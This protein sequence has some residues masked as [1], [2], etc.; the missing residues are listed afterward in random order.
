MLLYNKKIL[1]SFEKIIIAYSGGVDSHS[2]LHLLATDD[3]LA[4][5]V[6]AVHVNHGLS[7]NA[8][9]WEAY[10]QKICDA[11]SIP[12]KIVRVM[13]N[14]KSGESI[15]AAARN[16]RYAALANFVTK[17]EVL[18]T[19]QHHDDQ[20]ETMLLQLLR[21]AGVKGL[22]AMPIL[23]PFAAGWHVRPLLHVTQAALLEY[24]Q[25]Q[26]LRWIEDE[27]N[28]DVRFSRNYL[29]HKVMP[30]LKQHW[31]SATIALVRSSEHCA[32]A[33]ELLIDLAMLDIQSCM[34]KEKTLAITKLTAL[35]LARQHNVLRHWLQQETNQ[36][37]SSMLI[38][39]IVQEVMLAKKDAQPEVHWQ[40]G[41][42]RRF[43]QSLYFLPEVIQ[44]N[45]ATYEWDW[46]S[47][48]I[49]QDIKLIANEILG[50]G[51][52][53]TKLSHK[54][55]VTFRHGGEKIRPHGR[56]ETHL[57]KKLFQEWQVPPWERDKIPL[58]FI[59]EKLI[60]VVGYCY[61]HDYAV[62]SENI[63]ITLETY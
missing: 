62:V 3:E 61:H 60:A 57:L 44:E 56:Q 55:T 45:I 50:A 9:A 18:V 58:I 46:Q 21:G 14:C 28:I 25:R 27:S 51:L 13:V 33:A 12:L 37:P 63:G 5:K 53:K 29:R 38:Q 2:L 10:C 34:G 43:N 31:P 47:P 36:F 8:N 11:L 54:L 24:A 59:A 23:K 52:D 17:N 42:I 1:Q 39:K 49:Y 4:N 41:V 19:A 22:A 15:E 26:D 32:Q 40:G 20:A 7:D 16:T 30:L 48:L 35:S 6:C